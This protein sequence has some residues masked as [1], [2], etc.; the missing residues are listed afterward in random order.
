MIMKR[1]GH[2]GFTLLELIVVI[3]ILGI[4][5]VAVIMVLDPVAQLQ[6]SNDVRRKSDI[7]QIQRALESYYQDNNHYPIATIAP[8]QIPGVSWGNSWQPYMNILPQDPSSAKHYAYYSNGQTYYIYANLERGVSDA[9]AC[10]NLDSNGE[11]P[12]ISINQI[13]AKS[14]GGACNFGVSSPDVS[15]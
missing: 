5:A 15:P 2:K 6:K 11:C 3:G 1:F 7:A 12:S 10:K 4:L 9:S 8:Y 14:C 13:T